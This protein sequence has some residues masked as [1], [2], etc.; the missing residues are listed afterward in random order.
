VIPVR[1]GNGEMERLR[2]LGHFTPPT[3][4]QLEDVINACQGLGAVVTADLWDIER[5]AAADTDAV[6]RLRR[7]N[8]GGA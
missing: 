5:L 4:P 3:L 6:E 8:L 1:G 7:M 2:A